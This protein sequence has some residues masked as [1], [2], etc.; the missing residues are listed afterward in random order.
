MCG[1]SKDEKNAFN[2]EKSVSSQ[3]A[4]NFKTLSDQA[5]SIFGSSSQ[6]FKDLTSAF[7]PIL[8]AGPGQNGYTASELANLKSQAIT[9]T[10]MAYRNASQAAGERAAAAG[11]GNTLLPSGSTAQMQAN[12]AQAGAGATAGALSNINLQNSELGRQNWLQAAG[13]LG[14]APGVFNSATGAGGILQGSGSSAMQGAN[15]VFND[16]QTV[17]SQENWWLKPVAG[18]LGGALSFVPGVGPMLGSAVAG[19]GGTTPMFGPSASMG[20]MGGGGGA[21]AGPNVPEWGS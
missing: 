12:I 15:Q 21:S 1:P 13:V 14:G 20:G 7:E 6:I 4:S 16:A 10:G 11:G 8:S 5:A 18:A 17:Q 2:T 9:Q 3:Q 19:M